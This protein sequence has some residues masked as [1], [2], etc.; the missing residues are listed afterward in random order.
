MLLTS[1]KDRSRHNVTEEVSLSGRPQ[2][3]Q[4]LTTADAGLPAPLVA[5]ASSSDNI[6]GALIPRSSDPKALG[7]TLGQLHHKD[8]PLNFVQPAPTHLPP[9][10]T[11]SFQPASESE[12]GTTDDEYHV[13]NKDDIPKVASEFDQ[14]PGGWPK[15]AS[16]VRWISEDQQPLLVPS[17]LVTAPPIGAYPKSSTQIQPSPFARFLSRPAKERKQPPI[18]QIPELEDNPK[19]LQSEA[20]VR[21]V[22]GQ[23]GGPIAVLGLGSMYSG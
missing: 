11:H 9:G 17:G 4:R 15:Q 6:K 23:F 12:S 21:T 19:P 16:N 7:Q 22:L 13:L 18:E 2:P 10:I 5:H 3:P 14:K 1:T 20:Q 8:S